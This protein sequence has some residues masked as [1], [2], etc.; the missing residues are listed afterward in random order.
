MDRKERRNMTFE[1]EHGI[2]SRCEL[3]YNLN[4][5]DTKGVQYMEL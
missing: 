5:V 4:D 2:R 3:K 1:I